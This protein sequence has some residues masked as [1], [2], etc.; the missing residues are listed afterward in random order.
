MYRQHSPGEAT[1]EE[2]RRRY[3]AEGGEF[4]GNLSPFC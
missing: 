1:A 2:R 3:Q 4:H